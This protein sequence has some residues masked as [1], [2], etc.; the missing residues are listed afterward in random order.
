MTRRLIRCRSTKGVDPLL[1]G[2]RVNTFSYPGCPVHRVT[3]ACASILSMSDK[4]YR[5]PRPILRHGRIPAR[6]RRLRVS[7]EH[8]QRSA[9]ERRFRCFVSVCVCIP[10]IIA[11][12]RAVGRWFSG[13]GVPA[14]GKLDPTGRL[15][16]LFQTPDHKETP[17]HLR[18]GSL[19]PSLRPIC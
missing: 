16:R 12:E 6:S 5:T 18:K 11:Q 8:T 1:P 4:R 9:R 17:S 19:R 3:S 10:E 2:I 7:M 13:P 15:G 14:R